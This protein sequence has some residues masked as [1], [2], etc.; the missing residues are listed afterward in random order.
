MPKSA[1]ERMREY[2]ARRKEAGNPAKGG[3]HPYDASKR[4][5]NWPGP[6][7]YLDGEAYETEGYTLLQTFD[8][9]SDTIITTESDHGCLSSDECFEH[10]FKSPKAKL[11][12][13]GLGY[14][15]S[16]W[17]RDLSREALQH[18]LNRGFVRWSRW[19]IDYIPGKMLKVLDRSREKGDRQRT[20]YDLAPFFQQP[21]IGALI[22]AGISVPEIIVIGKKMRGKFL[23][24][25]REFV[26]EYNVAELRAMFQLH[27]YLID[28]LKRGDCL[29]T[30]WFGPGSCARYAAK[31]HGVTVA[32]DQLSEFLAHRRDPATAGLLTNEELAVRES[33]PHA[34]VVDAFYGGRF[35]LSQHGPIEACWEYD[36]ASAYPWGLA[37]GMPCFACGGA[38]TSTPGK[39]SVLLVSWRPKPG[40]EP[41]WG[42]FPLRLTR[43]LAW[44]KEGCGW[45]HAVEVEA[46]IVHLGQQYDFQVHRCWSWVPDCEHDPWSWVGDAAAERVRVKSSDP[47]RAKCLKL[48]LN[49]LYGIT[50]DK[51]GVDNGRVPRY[52]NPYW[53]G[54][55][56]ARTRARLIEASAVGGEDIVYLA[57]DGVHSK[58]PLP[59][60][61]GNELGAWE[62]PS[63]AGV[64]AVFLAP[65]TYLYADGKR[66]K[67]R[68]VNLGK[69]SE[70]IETWRR[71]YRATS[72]Q[73]YIRLR[74]RH[75]CSVREA[76]SRCSGK[77]DEE[78]RQLMNTWSDRERLLSYDL[79]PRRERRADGRWVAPGLAYWLSLGQVMLVPNDRTMVQEEAW[80]TDQPEWSEHPLNACRHLQG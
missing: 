59:L 54:L 4:K 76:L 40:V 6:F 53:A 77:S 1:A 39:W 28:I 70:R 7:V 69:F 62:P 74:E 12:G 36:L 25:N 10:L 68:G 79:T 15:M 72:G 35:E 47:G 20:V 71:L 37:S 55:I 31:E 45:Y 65:G 22:D 67:S 34:C 29:I 23:R 75:F 52:H 5:E 50:A 78:F 13:Y 60:P 73:D 18:L 24:E 51:A 27:K 30:H 42:P 49:S 38:W 57:T 16:N 58:R 17:L 44:T 41:M 43:N 61:V 80:S 48:Q 56:T 66:G 32:A 21:F 8:P 3:A 9:R 64:G 19:K 33:H 14:D 26:S 2:R 46:A 63:R 11:F